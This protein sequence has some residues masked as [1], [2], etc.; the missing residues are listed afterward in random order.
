MGVNYPYTLRHIVNDVT[1]N[2]SIVAVLDLKSENFWENLK[3]HAGGDDKLRI[4]FA[5]PKFAVVVY[6]VSLDI[7]HLYGTIV[8]ALE[9]TPTIKYLCGF[10][11]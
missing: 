9:A 8:L 2:G 11:S 7:A 3:I 6:T 5:P 1:C 10:I 4:Q